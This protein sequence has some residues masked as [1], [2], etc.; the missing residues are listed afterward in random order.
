MARL[1]AVFDVLESHNS[2]AN[3]LVASHG[4][5]RW[6]KMFEDLD[7]PLPERSSEIFEDEMRIR[8]RDCAPR[9]RRQIMAQKDVM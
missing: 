4:F 2:T 5:S 7:N 9:W 1:D 6:K 3:F 8:F